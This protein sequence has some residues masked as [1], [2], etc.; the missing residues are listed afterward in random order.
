VFEIQVG[1]SKLKAFFSS[2]SQKSITTFF[3]PTKCKPVQGASSPMTS[4]FFTP[5]PQGK[6]LV[7]GAKG[8]T[9]PTLEM[10]STP[11]RVATKSVPRQTASSFEGFISIAH[12]YQISL[13]KQAERF[14]PIRR[15]HTEKA[16]S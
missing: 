4:R 9:E 3:T 7:G 12:A 8:D 2:M 5:S 1:K 16:Q 15:Y 13:S 11:T 10:L 14:I 6:V